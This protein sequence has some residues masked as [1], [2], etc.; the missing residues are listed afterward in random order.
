MFKNMKASEKIA[1]FSVLV[2]ILIFGY[3]VHTQNKNSNKAASDRL[4][5]I[6]RLD[7]IHELNYSQR[8]SQFQESIEGVEARFDST[9]KNY[10]ETLKQTT[11]QTNISR[12]QLDFAEGKLKIEVERA[13]EQ[14]N[15]TLTALETV[16]KSA[17]LN[18]KMAENLKEN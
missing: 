13:K 17:F 8:D 11:K 12:G 15:L 9:I 18:Y 10:N 16:S 1:S 5:E 6:K 14:Y 3:S 2:S 7:S 4:A